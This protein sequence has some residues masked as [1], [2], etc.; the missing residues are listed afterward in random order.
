MD[1]IAYQELFMLAC[2]EGNLVKIKYL[3]PR[4]PQG[5]SESMILFVLEK[6]TIEAAKNGKLE[7]LYYLLDNSGL[8]PDHTGLTP[9]LIAACRENQE[10][11][12]RAL[13]VRMKEVQMWALHEASQVSNLECFKLLFYRV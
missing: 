6:G 7:I 2:A 9:V 1:I 10:A 13:I 3:I 4:V 11:V 12:V 5:T 8:Y